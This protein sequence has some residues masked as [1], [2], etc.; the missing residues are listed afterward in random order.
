M[1]LYIVLD[2]FPPCWSYQMLL[3]SSSVLCWQFSM[4]SFV[5][6]HPWTFLSLALREQQRSTLK[7]PIHHTIISKVFHHQCYVASK[8]CIMI[9][10]LQ[11]NAR[12]EHCC[13]LDLENT[14][15]LC[16]ESFNFRTFNCP[17]GPSKTLITLQILLDPTFWLLSNVENRQTSQSRPARTTCFLRI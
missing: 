14:C 10:P 1:Q 7:S 8:A 4:Q 9:S 12:I 2:I 5:L 13:F 11:I 15:W 17:P 16:I 3:F 6:I